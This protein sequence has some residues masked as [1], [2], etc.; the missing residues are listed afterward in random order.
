M[1]EFV[2]DV[3]TLDR[4]ILVVKVRSKDSLEEKRQFVYFVDSK[5]TQN[6]DTEKNYYITN[7]QNFFEIKKNFSQTDDLMIKI[8]TGRNTVSRNYILYTGYETGDDMKITVQEEE[9]Q[10]EHTVKFDY[11]EYFEKDFIETTEINLKIQKSD[12]GKTITSQDGIKI[13]ADVI[14][15][16]C[17]KSSSTSKD[18]VCL[19]PFKYLETEVQ[20]NLKKTMNGL[21]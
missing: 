11:V 5:Y 16:S 20:K 19:T 13:R 3:T 15:R 14:G 4:K 9:K 18:F 10:A 7:S 1:D 21:S 8:L 12:R 17:T 6:I 2:E